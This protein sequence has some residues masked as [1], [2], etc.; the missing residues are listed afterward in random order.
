MTQPIRLEIITPER[1]V[2]SQEVQTVTAPGVKGE[3]G[4]LHGHIP[5]L[6]QLQMGCVRYRTDSGEPQY[7]F[8]AGGIIQVL[9]NAVNILTPA[10]ERVEDIDIDRAERAKERALKRLEEQEAHVDMAR[11]QA[12]LTRAISRIHIAKQG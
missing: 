8:V 1:Q 3:F 2:F 6:T 9:P 7:L 10:A 4:V 12:A 5:F 11:A